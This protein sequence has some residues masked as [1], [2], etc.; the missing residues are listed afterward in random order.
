MGACC[1][2][3]AN[4]VHNTDIPLC[5]IYRADKFEGSCKTLLIEDSHN[6][7]LQS[8]LSEVGCVE[9]KDADIVSCCKHD[10]K[11]FGLCTKP[12]QQ[13][14]SKKLPKHLDGGGRFP[15]PAIIELADR[16]KAIPI[17]KGVSWDGGRYT[18]CLM[19]Q[20]G[21][22]EVYRLSRESNGEGVI[23]HIVKGV[24]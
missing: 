17:V 14:E 3:T 19:S 10:T 11:H 4:A 22:N 8:R 9:L 16:D 23:P 21:R 13:W 12:C 1:S 2:G 6:C 24:N 7:I 5:S 18:G 15:L 20:L